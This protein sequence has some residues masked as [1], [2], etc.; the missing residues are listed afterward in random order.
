[1][2]Q[3]R[4]ACAGYQDAGRW[5]SKDPARLL[6]AVQLCKAAQSWRRVARGQDEPDGIWGGVPRSLAR[7]RAL[8][9]AAQAVGG[10]A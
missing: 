5:F 2:W 7:M 8:E 6:A 1:M 10:A 4:A 9:L 3:D